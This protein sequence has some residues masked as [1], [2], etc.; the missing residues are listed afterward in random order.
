MWIFL[1]IPKAPARCRHTSTFEI[2]NLPLNVQAKFLRVLK[3]N[4]I[5]PLGSNQMYKINVRFIAALSR[6]LRELVESGEFREDLLYRLYVYPIE[7]PS[8]SQRCE[9]IPLLVQHFLRK[10]I[11][12][13]QKKVPNISG[14]L[15]EFLKKQPWIGNIRELENLVE[16]QVTL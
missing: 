14:D 5:R 3:E 2:T 1:I 15:L 9:D 4:E 7:I 6:S 13:Q 11:R 8:L 10:F 16:R 12:E